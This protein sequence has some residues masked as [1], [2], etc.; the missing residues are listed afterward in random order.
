MASPRLFLVDGTALAYRSFFAF[1]RNPLTTSKGMNTSAVFGFTQAM[2]RLREGEPDGHIVVAWDARGPTFRHHAY[3][4]YKATREKMPDEMLAQLPFVEQ[5]AEALG[6][7]FLALPGWEADD[8]IGT[9]AIEGARR[10][11]RVA[12]VAADKDFMQLV[13]ERIALWIPKPGG[14]FDKVTADGVKQ[15]MGV[16]PERIIDLL[17]LMGDS[18]DNV[19]GVRG[20]GEKTARALLEQFDTLEAA[21]D[22]ADQVKS[23]KLGEK[24]VASRAEALLSK[25]L[26][27]IDT[28]APVH[29]DEALA[30]AHDPDRERLRE[31]FA[32]LEFKGMLR[33]VA[34]PAPK[35]QSDY[36][37]TTGHSETRDL[38]ARLGKADE[39]VFHIAAASDR[40]DGIAFAAE[41]GHASYVPVGADGAA[42]AGLA[43][44]LEDGA[45]RKGTH[46]AK[47]ALKSLRR[48]G[49]TLR[50]IAFDTMIASYL[51]DPTQ[52]QAT[53]DDLALKY[54]GV[55]RSSGAGP[56]EATQRELF[57]PPPEPA[58]EERGEAACADADLTLKLH[59]HLAPTIE[60]LGVGEL[61]R[62]LELPLVEVLAAME[63]RGVKLDGAL[64]SRMSRD[65]EARLQAL[66]QELHQLA[67]E[68][69]NV[70]SPRQLGTVL[71]EKLAIQKSHGPSRVRRTKT[72]YSTDAEVLEQYASHPIVAKVLESRV[73]SKLKSTYLDAL[74]GLADPATGR[75]HTSYNQAVAA[76][77]RLS[78]SDPN[79]QNIPIRTEEGRAIRK[80]FVA[81]DGCVLLSADYSQI[82]L[83]ILAHLS[84]DEG[85]IEVFR[86][87][88]DVH[89]ETAARV[90]KAKPEDVTLELRSRSKAINFGIVYGMG[91]QRLARETS[92]T[93]PEAKAFIH[94]YFESYPGVKGYIDR[95]VAHARE[96]GSVETLLG[97]RRNLPEI[98]SSNGQI[99]INAENAA[100]N[101][102]IQGSAADL[103][104]RAMNRL[105]RRLLSEGRRAGMIM[106]VHDELVLEV[107]EA[108][109]ESVTAAVREEM[110]GAIRLDVPL[111][112]DVGHGRSWLEAHG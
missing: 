35:V 103:I 64:L 109:L 95:T 19:P 21:L 84:A 83:R 67:G 78:S 57:A 7:P 16:P 61:Y 18:S 76:T 68:E 11:H 50:G 63:L 112:V 75:I 25:Q 71:F 15:R 2:T 34:R 20:V 6:L 60:A 69:F 1:I 54:L 106:Q 29:L 102:P 52:R 47:E 91:P 59:R 28:K 41:P 87:G 22:G 24:L 53:L 13:G 105:H 23:K 66:E 86:G 48:R 70:N 49:V 85:L 97:R 40:I 17:G 108:E 111:K 94:S 4:E 42:L 96:T 55:R 9:L 5:V 88:R 77:G 30:N 8:I 45:R 44:L 110:E 80:A 89:R 32:E 82:E 98:H 27:T 3:A 90:F 81:D 100:V 101:T 12:I 43:P 92:L 72:G 73:L 26:V 33:T 46:D 58:G 93:V 10:G 65:F 31:L 37:T 74:P 79:L 107:P 51:V 38:A 39:W 14:D 62:E 104:K 56:G 36:S 99:R